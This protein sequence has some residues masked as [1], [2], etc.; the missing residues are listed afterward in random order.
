MV[1]DEYWK[2]GL[3]KWLGPDVVP[4]IVR[5]PFS[6]TKSLADPVTSSLLR[7]SRIEAV[8]GKD[9]L[10]YDATYVR[11]PYDALVAF[12][13][14]ADN[15]ILVVLR[16][17]GKEISH[18]PENTFPLETW[19]AGLFSLSCNILI[20]LFSVGGIVHDAVS[21]KQFLAY[22]EKLDEAQLVLCRE[23]FYAVYPRERASV[24]TRAFYKLLGDVH[25]EMSSHNVL[26]Y[27]QCVL[28]EA[29]AVAKLMSAKNIVQVQH[30][31][32][33]KLQRR[34]SK[35]GQLPLFSWHELCVRQVGHR[36]EKTI[37]GMGSPTAIHWVRGHFKTYTSDRPLFGKHVGQYWWQPHLAG[38]DEGRFVGKTYVL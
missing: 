25:G 2:A 36:A 7:S 26:H 21:G 32:P 6:L 31:P 24:Y 20:P 35:R 33:K 23:F 22:A 27:A 11:M 37:D 16:T 29:F 10:L 1:V 9:G 5:V 28:F 14:R 13:D 17:P 8:D 30:V 18:A 34:R 38:R 19:R 4:H 3:G 12:H 15:A